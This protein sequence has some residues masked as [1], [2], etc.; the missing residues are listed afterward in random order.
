[1]AAQ[2]PHEIDHSKEI[3]TSLVPEIPPRIYSEFD[4]L[5]V[6]Q[7]MTQLEYLLSQDLGLSSLEKHRGLAGKLQEDWKNRWQ[8]EY[9]KWKQIS[10]LAGKEQNRI[11]DEIAKSRPDRMRPT[12]RGVPDA[13]SL[14]LFG[15]DSLSF[16]KPELLALIPPTTDAEKEELGEFLS[17]LTDLVKL[18]REE[19]QLALAPSLLYTQEFA[20]HGLAPKDSAL[21]QEWMLNPQVLQILLPDGDNESPFRA[22][23]YTSAFNRKVTDLGQVP[24]DLQI[25]DRRLLNSSKLLVSLKLF[26][27]DDKIIEKKMAESFQGEFEVAFGSVGSGNPADVGYK[28]HIR[29]SYQYDSM[30]YPMIAAVGEYLAKKKISGKI[31]LPEPHFGFGTRWEST[32]ITIW[33]TPPDASEED[34]QAYFDA[35]LEDILALAA[36]LELLLA[37]FP[38]KS[39][40]VA[41]SDF[42]LKVGRNESRR[43]SL[44]FGI[45]T[46]NKAKAKQWQERLSWE[47]DDRDQTFMQ[48]FPDGIN[49]P[50]TNNG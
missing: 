8:S 4:A 15:D 46:R 33:G 11:A 40:P 1:M 35:Q 30:L 5:R 22:Q 32:L 16:D 42:D 29:G 47:D 13:F 28:L 26:K 43:L 20:P 19:F 24:Q 17:G 36:E 34:L 7:N 27:V 50:I 41:H 6:T 21:L 39:V 10:E 44:R 38:N 12:M 31:R 3:D 18:V 48:N 14:F 49:F 9:K 2:R 23:A 37:A 25:Q 45:N